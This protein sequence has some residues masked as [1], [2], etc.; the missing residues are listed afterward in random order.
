[1][2]SAIFAPSLRILS[3]L[4]RVEVDRRLI[5]T[6]LLHIRRADC[7]L[8]LLL[9]I[10]IALLF[11]VKALDHKAVIE[12]AKQLMDLPSIR[13]IV[14][15]LRPMSIVTA[16]LGRV[17][18]VAWVRATISEVL[19]IRYRADAAMHHVVCDGRCL[20]RQLKLVVRLI[21]HLFH[22]LR[23]LFFLRL[24]KSR[25]DDGLHIFDNWLLHTG[26]AH[27]IEDLPEFA[28][29]CLESSYNLALLR[30]ALLRVCLC[31]LADTVARWIPRR[32]LS[33]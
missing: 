5:N 29:L 33:A 11:T 14:R 32:P 19:A 10:F 17:K 18:H 31:N 27:Q 25:V 8:F 13:T 1:M 20:I 3:L 12:L 4:P 2:K 22:R 9:L 21:D 6:F 24:A 16:I 30:Y 15:D 23:L 7:L 28:S 26:H